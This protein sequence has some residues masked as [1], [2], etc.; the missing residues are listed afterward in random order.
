MESVDRARHPVDTM[1]ECALQEHQNTYN[2]SPDSICPVRGDDIIGVNGTRI[3]TGNSRLIPQVAEIGS[4]MANHRHE[5]LG[6]TG[7]WIPGTLSRD[8]VS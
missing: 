2:G 1:P 8:A 4:K 5:S 6:E 3:R 7:L